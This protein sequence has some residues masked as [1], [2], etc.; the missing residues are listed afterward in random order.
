[1]TAAGRR[2]GIDVGGTKCLGVILDD[3][4]EMIEE[5]RCP[6]P[7]G[8]EAIIATLAELARSMGPWD[9]IGIGVP[10]LVTRSGVLRA[11]PNLV[12]ITNFEVG[13]L[14]GVELGA[15]VFVDND[16]TC[17]AAA[18]WKTG[19]AR[20]VDDFVMVTLGTGIGGG[21]IAGGALIRGAN[22]FTGEIGHMVVDPEGP[23]CPCGRRGCWERYASG[24]GLAR[25]A[26]EAAVG[27]RLERV[28]NLAG[29]DAEKVRGEDVQAAAR[30]GDADALQVIDN[31]GRWV[32]LG[33]ANLTNI[34]DPESFVL[35]GGLAASADLYLG[36]IQKW[37]T[38]LLYAPHLRPHPSLMFAHL[39][40]RAG[41]VGAA[42]LAVVH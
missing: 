15:T 1:M 14:L 33:L 34:L 10:G 36:P 41:A 5:Q 20:G 3:A 39:G 42:L 16:G 37:F 12:D 9:S 13:R 26:R 8:P 38:Q 30:E 31:F 11:A 32:A 29:G 23:P 40:E 7:K 28:V 2:L 25:L 27:R 17:A 35:G 18:E 4:G 21:V 19:A 24:S 22:G 6:T